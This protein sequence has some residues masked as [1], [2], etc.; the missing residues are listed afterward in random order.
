MFLKINNVIHP[1]L[2]FYKQQMMKAQGK[3]LPALFSIPHS[4]LFIKHL[5]DKVF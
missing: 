5:F 4:Y 1:L 3:F 2:T